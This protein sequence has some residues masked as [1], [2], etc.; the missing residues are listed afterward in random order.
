MNIIIKTGEVFNHI[1]NLFGA[2]IIVP[3]IVLIISIVMGVNWKKALNG[4]LYMAVGLVLFNAVL[5]ILLGSITPYINQMAANVGISLPYVDVGWQGAAAIVYSNRLGYIYLVLGLGVNLLMF[6]LKL[7]DTFQP[8]DIWNY[9][10]FVF[11]AVIVQVVSGSFWIGLAAAVFMNLIVLL[12]ADIIAPSLQE[13]NGYENVTNTS[14]PQGGAAPAIIFAWILRKLGYKGNKFNGENLSGKLGAFGNTITIGLIV[15][16]IIAI[17]GSINKIGQASTWGGILTTALTVAGVM[18]IYPNVSS[19]FVK[20]LVPLSNSMNERVSKGSGKGR[21]Y[22]NVAMDPAIFFGHSSNLTAAMILIPIVFLISLFLP[23]N[24]IMLLADIPAMPFMTAVIIAIFRGDV[25]MTVIFGAIH[26]SFCNIFIS[27]VSA[28][29]T[30]A[31]QAAGIANQVPAVADAFSQNLG[32]TVFT[33]GSNPV[34]YAVT[35]AFSAEGMWKWIGIA[36]C[37]AV[38]LLVFTLFRKNRKKFWMAAGASE[39][40]LKERNLLD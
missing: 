35:K 16:F 27:D 10:Q 25:L 23:G 6:G 15:G 13:F 20:G 37:I 30:Q 12:T 7:T 9:Y 29:F 5:G 1:M 36:I 8:T 14:C 21:K 4:S 11:W 24:K 32:V 19:L 40:F 3:I 34:L 39:D 26:F 33:V 28:A 17:L 38:Y 18:I 2:P 22:F 31:A